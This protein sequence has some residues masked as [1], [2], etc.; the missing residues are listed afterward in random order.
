[1][2]PIPASALASA[3]ASS[4]DVVGLVQDVVE[5]LRE[6]A[7]LGLRRSP[8]E[9]RDSL[10]A[11]ERVGARLEHQ[12]GHLGSLGAAGGE[13]G[14]DGGR[15]GRGRV[16]ATRARLG[17]GSCSRP[18]HRCERLRSDEH[19]RFDGIAV[20]GEELR[21]VTATVTRMNN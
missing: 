20:R 5:G 19:L 11:H 4:P 2:E 15:Y 9:P 14:G 13:Q 3:S 10:G 7:I 18:P 16:E 1:M 8:H 21:H 6:R 17:Q 12:H